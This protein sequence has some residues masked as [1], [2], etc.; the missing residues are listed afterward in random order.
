MA[1]PSVDARL[2]ALQKSGR[3]SRGGEQSG[4]PAAPR[5]RASE[6]TRRNPSG[7]KWTLAG[8][9]V[10]A[11]L[12]IMGAM[13]AATRTNEPA[14]TARAPEQVQPQP[15]IIV[16]PQQ[17]ATPG[18]SAE[19]PTLPATVDQAIVEQVVQA[20]NESPTPAPSAAPVEAEANTESGGS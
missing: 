13:S 7:S 3:A 15:I 19:I 9:A 11:T 18:V 10:G 5:P 12:T 17:T 1:D 4:K 16:M 14:P 2:Q 8:G 6:P 20:A